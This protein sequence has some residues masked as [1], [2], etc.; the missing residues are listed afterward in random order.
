M[1]I[2]LDQIYPD[3]RNRPKKI[4]IRRYENDMRGSVSDFVQSA[5]VRCR[6]LQVD[7]MSRPRGIRGGVRVKEPNRN[8]KT[9][10]KSKGL[11]IRKRKDLEKAK[12]RKYT[13]HGST[14]KTA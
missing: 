2:L 14:Q 5:A 9:L 7:R 11:F 13:L 4:I 3:W 8:G 6:L 10:T 12:L 1:F